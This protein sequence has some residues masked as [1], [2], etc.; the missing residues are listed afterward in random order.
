MS[1]ARI[2]REKVN[3]RSGRTYFIITNFSIISVIIVAII[4][5]IN[6]VIIIVPISIVVTI[7]I[8][9]FYFFLRNRVSFVFAYCS[10]YV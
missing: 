9:I 4:T 1:W 7:N 5:I 8:V 3:C 10:C 6:I 2:V